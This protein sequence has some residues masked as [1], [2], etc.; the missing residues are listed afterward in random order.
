MTHAAPAPDRR[1]SVLVVSYST[2]VS[3][4]RLLRQIRLL[5]DEYD[6]TSC[7]Y[8]Q[9]PDGVVAHVRI[10][11][12][13]VA[14][15]KDRL[16]LMQRR[17]AAV[18]E[19]N[20]V[21]AH[22]RKRLPVGEFDVVVANDADTV[23]LALSLR[24]R[25]G[26]HA[27]LHEYAPRQHEDSPRWRLFVAP[28]YRWLVRKFLPLCA[29]VTTVGQGLAAEYEREYGARTGVVANAAP[30]REATPTAVSAPLRLVHSGGS[31]RVR[32]IHRMIRAVEASTSGATLDLFLVPNDPAYHAEL[33]EL[34]AEADRVTLHDPVPADN[35]VETIAQYDVGVYVLP[36]TGFNTQNAL[37]NKFFD[38]VQARLGI[39]VGPSPEMASLVEEHGLGAVTSGFEEADLAV[40]LDRLDPV[41]VARWKAGSDAAARELSAENQMDAWS[42]AVAALAVRARQTGRA[43]QAARAT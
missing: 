31:M 22:L 32:A 1:P 38:F 40:V 16:L 3:D 21:N 2:L 26:V 41:E 25:G 35:V 24:P 43:R 4:A 20:S 14:W 12:G 15:H 11:D 9:A 28:Y 37:P 33:T 6:V 29:S 30:F 7:G 39:I 23:P 13:L 18:Y 27:D 34:A 5:A 10:P 19:R 8:G 36:P 17:F 42:Y